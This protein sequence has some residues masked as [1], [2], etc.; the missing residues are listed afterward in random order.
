MNKNALA[1]LIA[2]ALVLIAGTALIWIPAAVILG[3]LMLVGTGVLSLELPER[4]ER[5]L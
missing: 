2:G 5:R 1:F 3:G 4:E